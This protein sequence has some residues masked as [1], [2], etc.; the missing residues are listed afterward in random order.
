[1]PAMIRKAASLRT[2]DLNVMPRGG[3]RCR[4]RGR[5]SVQSP[6]CREPVF[7]RAAKRHQH[8]AKNSNDEDRGIKARR[9]RSPGLNA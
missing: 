8:N 3:A 4:W 5:S 9:Y 1:M 7:Q 2:I 6:P